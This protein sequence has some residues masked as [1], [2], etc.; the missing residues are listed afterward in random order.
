MT[1]DAPCPNCQA[2]VEFLPA[3]LKKDLNRML[4]PNWKS[5]VKELNIRMAVSTCSV[6]RAIINPEPLTGGGYLYRV[7]GFINENGVAE[8]I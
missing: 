6:C 8:Y 5:A 1:H 2:K 7:V 3:F 4:R